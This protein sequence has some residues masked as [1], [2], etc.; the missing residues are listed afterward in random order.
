LHNGKKKMVALTAAMRKLLV[1]LNRLL[2]N[3]DF[4]LAA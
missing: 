3:P 1:L 4:T 2:K